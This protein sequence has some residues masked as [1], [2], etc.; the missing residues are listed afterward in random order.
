M[1]IYYQSDSIGSIP[2]PHCSLKF[3]YFLMEFLGR[4]LPFPVQICPR[5]GQPVVSH[6]NAIG[7]Q[8]RDDSKYEVLA[9]K[10]SGLTIG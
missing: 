6:Y 1:Q 5:V 8:H 7:I 3:I 10:L 2:L 4:F 9:E